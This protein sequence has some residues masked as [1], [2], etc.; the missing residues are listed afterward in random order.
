M[1]QT[2]NS[3]IN[4]TEIHKSKAKDSEI[5]AYRLCLAN[6]SKGFSVDNLKQT[7]LKGKVYDF[8]VD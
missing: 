4:G 2:V 1:E 5:M 6:I 8:S 3:F 7:V